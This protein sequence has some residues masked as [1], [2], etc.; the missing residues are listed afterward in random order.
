MSI[1]GFVH[2]LPDLDPAETQEWLDSLNAVI[3]A[4]GKTRAR[5]ILSRLTELARM[6][7]VGAPTEVSTPYVNTI[8]TEAQPWFPGD[9]HIERRIRAFI[10]WNAAVMVVKANKHADG[11]GGHLST[12]ASSAALYEVGFNHFFRGKEDGRPGDHVYIQGH[13]APGIYARAFLERRL[14]EGQLDNFR[15][16]LSGPA[17][18]D[19]GLSSYPHPKLMPDF[20]ESPT[21]SMGI[22]PINSIYQARFNKYLHNRQIDDT[23]D[24][25]V[26]CFVGDG[27][28][29]EP[30]TLGSISLAAREQL[31]NLTWVINCNL[32]R[33]DGPVR[34]N[35]K[36]IQELEQIFRGAGWNVIKVIWGSKWDE[37]LA[38]DVDGVLLHKMNTTVDGEFQRYAVESGAYIRE[39]FFGPDPR[40]RKM[41]E[42][43]SDEE[44]RSLPRGGHDYGKLYAAYKAASEQRGAPTVILAKT[45]KGWALGADVEGRNATHQIKKMTVD[46]LKALRERLHMED[47][48]PDSAFEGDSPPYYRPAEDSPEYQYLMKRRKALDGPLPSRVVQTRRP[49]TLPE[50]AEFAELDKG[51]GGREVSTTMAFTGLLR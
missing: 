34:G 33:L 24:S 44:L 51:S 35:S 14:D 31:D 19:P 36:I 4:R 11:I 2:Q 47:L 38:Q 15:R 10:R 50:P 32:Q 46:Q 17:A 1:D 23:A 5:F 21:V 27:E 42:H 12:F 8:P 26:W 22:G 18:N 13:A 45:V 40:L 41:V 39:H 6:R 43:L 25:R 16:E 20:W 9:E 30:E 28:C 29:D 48:V 49:L 37:L 7:Q 3:D